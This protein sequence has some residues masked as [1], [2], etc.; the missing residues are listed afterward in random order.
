L[1]EKALGP[2]NQELAES[3][4]GLANCA[5]KD[6]RLREAEALYERALTVA[7]KP[8]GSY[9][10]SAY[11]A[12]RGFAALLRVTHRD[13]RASEMETQLRALERRR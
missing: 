12:L 6:G 5:S 13:T 11:D 4:S 2:A 1:R 7:R 9:Y 3:L 8:D 10:P